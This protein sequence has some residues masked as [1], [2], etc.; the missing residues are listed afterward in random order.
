M[1]SEKL[2]QRSSAK[3]QQLES[4]IHFDKNASARSML[5]EKLESVTSARVE[6]TVFPEEFEAGNEHFEPSPLKNLQER[7]RKQLGL[8][9]VSEY[10][11]E[12]WIPKIRNG[13]PKHYV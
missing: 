2:S 13:A 3:K 4:E 8:G 9:G 1:I 5:L 12:K 11:E 10:L 7:S 6:K